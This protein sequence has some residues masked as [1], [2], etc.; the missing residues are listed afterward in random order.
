M[1][2]VCVTFTLLPEKAQSFMPLMMAQAENS[3][4]EE[5]L[6]HR[7]DVCVSDDG[8]TVFLYELYEDARAFRAHL[9][10]AHFHT[11]DA[12]VASM[13]LDKKIEQYSLIGA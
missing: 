1:H 7:F 12:A 13:V 6:C 11:F 4:R 9:D 2:V 10:T 5:T 8:T 3:L